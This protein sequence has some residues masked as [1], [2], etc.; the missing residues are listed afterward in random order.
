MIDTEILLDAFR[1]QE[2]LTPLSA[3][4]NLV[5]LAQAIGR[6]C[7]VEGLEVSPEASNI[8]TDIGDAD[9]IAL[10]LVDGMG[11]NMV[12]SLPDNS[13]LRRHL[14]DELRTVFPSTTAV[15][16]TSLT[17]AQWPAVHGVT[18]WWT[19]LPDLGS[20]ATVLQYTARSD[21]RDLLS[22]GIDPERSFPVKS[23][24]AL[25]PRDV[26]VIAPDKLAGSVYS[27]YFSGGR[28]TV[29]Y[30]SLSDGVD[31]TIERTR[32]TS[33][34]T[35]TYLYLPQVDSLAHL[36]GITRPEVKRALAQVNSE[37]E[38]LH[39]A[40]A[41]RTRVIVTAD[42]GFLDAP[43]PRR[44]TLR[45]TRELMP[46]LRF[47]PSGD[48]RVTYFHTWDWARDRVRRHIHRKFGDRFVVIDTEDAIAV[49]LF[50]PEYPTDEVAERFGDVMSISIG[51]D[52]LEYNVKR[53]P[54]RMLR[55]NSHHSGLSP[56]EM[57]IPL[58]VA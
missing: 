5:D 22:R 54:G 16:L 20:A 12:E 57:R 7:G 34:K 14:R 8:A 53:G 19:H 13:F 55:M 4:S 42:H 15:A 18:G 32:A 21:D 33:E 28:A 24:W 29:G 45:P 2:L 36:H 43:A 39:A 40:V 1:D 58:V 10:V 52:I 11:M 9:H 31:K 37:I 23:I 50:G 46:L 6:L 41:S 44:H 35:F 56:D 27:K 47:P 38:R 49:G 3:G 26:T 51:P 17:T 30:R 48:A 25:I